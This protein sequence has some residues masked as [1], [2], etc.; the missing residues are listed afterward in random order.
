[1]IGDA[2]GID[3]LGAMQV[4]MAQIYFNPKKI[5]HTENPTYEINCLSEIKNIL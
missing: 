1:M 5:P 2:L 4:G 3:I